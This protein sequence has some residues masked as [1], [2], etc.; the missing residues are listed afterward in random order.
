[1]EF[2]SNSEEVGL[3]AELLNTR[4]KWGDGRNGIVYAARSESKKKKMVSYD[5]TADAL[6]L[7]NSSKGLL[8]LQ[9]RFFFMQQV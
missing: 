5:T 6:N 1:M 3:G 7:R 8:V 2:V 4:P 9:V